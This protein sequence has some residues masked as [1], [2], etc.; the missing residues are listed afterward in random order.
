MLTGVM[1][2]PDQFPNFPPLRAGRHHAARS[3]AIHH[4]LQV[5]RRLFFPNMKTRCLALLLVLLALALPAPAKILRTAAQ[6]QTMQDSL[7]SLMPP[8]PGTNTLHAL[9]NAVPVTRYFDYALQDLG[10]ADA[11]TL[12]WVCQDTNGLGQLVVNCY[13]NQI[14]TLQSATNLAGPWLDLCPVANDSFVSF[15]TTN[16]DQQFFRLYINTSRWYV[17]F[18]QAPDGASNR[19]TYIVPEWGNGWWFCYTNADYQACSIFTNDLI[20]PVYPDAE[21]NQTS[22]WECGIIT[23]VYMQDG[24][25]T[26]NVT[27]IYMPAGCHYLVL[28]PNW[29]LQ[30]A[31]PLLVMPCSNPGYLCPQLYLGVAGNGDGTGDNGLG[32]G[33]GTG[34]G[35]DGGIGGPGIGYPSSGLGGSG[36]GW[37]PQLID[38]TLGPPPPPIQLPTGQ[39]PSLD[40][41]PCCLLPTAG[42]GLIVVPDLNPNPNT[43]PFYNH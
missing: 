17:T 29:L 5:A 39:P 33:S 28:E 30:Q 32:T 18:F 38:P 35:G 23:E 26:S 1:N 11:P 15:S 27:P 7:D 4:R 8:P 19:N 16:S 3:A 22:A 20:I 9:T 36:G 43:C 25:P 31:Q 40:L 13:S 34:A 12:Q 42:P 37:P 41:P 21:T 24:Q 2:A 6:M 14:C 10:P